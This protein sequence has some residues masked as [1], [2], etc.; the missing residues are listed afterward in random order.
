MI[1]LDTCRRDNLGCY[2][3]KRKVIGGGPESS[4]PTPNIDDFAGKAVLF[5]QAFA[6]SNITLMSF[7][8]F[9]TSKY[10][11]ALNVHYTP[12]TALSENPVISR[13]DELELTLPEILKMFNYQT[14]AFP[15]GTQLDPKYGLNRGFNIYANRPF[16]FKKRKHTDYRSEAMSFAD[17]LPTA[18][19]WLEINKNERFFALLHSN[20]THPP[21]DPPDSVFP[22]I[23]DPGYSGI[24]DKVKLTIQLLRGISG[25][26]LNTAGI[27]PER[28]F[29]EPYRAELSSSALRRKG[30]ISLD[31]RDI[32][33]V[34][35]H[36]DGSLAYADYCAG[37]ILDRLKESNLDKNTIV[38]IMADHGENLYERKKFNRVSSL[39][40]HDEIL[41][42]PLLIRHPGIENSAGKRIKETVQLL[43]IMPTL[44]S[45]LGI[46]GPENIQGKDLS[47]LINAYAAG[48]STAP[49]QTAANEY[50]YA[51]TATDKFSIRTAEWKLIRQEDS[52]EL[53]NLASD[54]GETVNL[55]RTETSVTTKLSKELD[56]WIAVNTDF[57]T[58]VSR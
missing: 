15:T 53:Y 28:D 7:S 4:S 30:E 55:S 58:P 8:S 29:R 22:H 13:M 27:K 10:P 40:L 21:Y 6:Q 25:L 14:I 54:P 17:F 5:E 49:W 32:N 2:G 26:R 12:G 18:L 52:V 46:P 41:K 3:Y 11:S 33:H 1:V 9:L 19:E 56:A 35:A 51:E 48:K 42:V 20:D 36:Y 16:D 38:L 23:Y 37:R 47:P 43:D 44:L 39:N 34:I 24:M 31:M 50:T 57:Y 45:M